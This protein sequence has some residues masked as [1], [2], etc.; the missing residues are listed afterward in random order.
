MIL[1]G[2]QCIKLNSYFSK[3]K[4]NTLSIDSDH[5][6]SSFEIYRISQGKLIKL[7]I[8]DIL[9]TKNVWLIYF[10]LCI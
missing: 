4:V 8:I 7:I 9:Y 1:C 5:N 3:S 6:D 10:G 2:K